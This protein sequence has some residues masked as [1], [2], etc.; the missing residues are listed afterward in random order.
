MTQFSNNHLRNKQKIRASSVSCTVEK[1]FQV[2]SGPTAELLL[3]LLLLLYLRQHG[4]VIKAQVT[5]VEQSYQYYISTF[6]NCLHIES[7]TS[8][9]FQ[10]LTLNQQ[11]AEHDQDSRFLANQYM[12]VLWH[13]YMFQVQCE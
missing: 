3:L 8:S 12:L 10:F 2:S 1:K 6:F 5:L 4:H 7:Q 13:V 11:E 9:N